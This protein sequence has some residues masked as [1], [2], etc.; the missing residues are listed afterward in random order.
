MRP[1]YVEIQQ[2]QLEPIGEGDDRYLI[3]YMHSLIVGSFQW[4]H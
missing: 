4:P 1:D 2:F 3:A